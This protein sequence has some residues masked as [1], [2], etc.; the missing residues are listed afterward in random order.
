MKCKYCGH[1]QPES[2][3]YCPE[4]GAKH[5]ENIF[6]NEHKQPETFYTE[7]PKSPALSLIKDKMFFFVCIFMAVGCIFSIAGGGLPLL[8]ILLTV[9]LWI[10]YTKGKNGV[11]D[12]EQL[13][14]VS[15]TVYASYVI[16]YIL[17]GAMILMGPLFIVLFS[18]IGSDPELINEAIEEVQ[19]FAGLSASVLSQ[20][21]GAF[22][23]VIGIIFIIIGIVMALLN[24]FCRG[25]IHKFLKSG[26][27]SVNDPSVQPV[28]AKSA[29]V[30]LIVLGI[31][32]GASALSSGIFAAVLGTL[33]F[34]V[35]Y[36][37]AGLLIQKYFVNK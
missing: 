4:C 2:F 5:E 1:E 6:E 16:N 3:V 32:N 18:F 21:F 36:I 12:Y 26:Y 17:A 35:A 29:S 11:A 28:K 20:F 25:T 27:M 33:A 9:F 24:Y 8:S 14:N 22:M 23:S 13:R 34:A 7:P 30:W 15:G 19:E 10:A 31:L 37:T